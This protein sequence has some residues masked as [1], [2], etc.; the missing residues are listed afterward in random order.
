MGK[1]DA[2]KIPATGPNGRLLKG[3]VLAFLG[4]IE[5]SYSAEQSARI[6][7]L[8]HLDLSNIKLAAPTPK[9]Q[10]TTAAAPPPVPVP[11]EEPDTEIALPIS[12]SAVL[13]CQKRIQDTLGIFLPVS[14]FVARAIELANE[15]LPASSAGTKPP[16]ADDLFN[17]VLGLP[18][19]S[20]AFSRGAFMPQITALAATQP[21]PA[22]Q[23]IVKAKPVDVYDVLTGA[24]KSRARLVQQEVP[25]TRH[26]K[27]A[28]NVFSVVAPKGD[29]KRAVVFLER[30]KT[31][32][33]AE[34]GRLVL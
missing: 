15:D 6:A 19:A 3:D 4:K 7:K 13:D 27:G 18:P 25:M 14:T 2:D 33:E 28:V 30:V 12:F 31:V 34:P 24:A 9:P 29:E 16:S 17:A 22:R 23:A 21:P 26:M 8:G 20:P 5:S 10:A 32:L 1:E 11:E